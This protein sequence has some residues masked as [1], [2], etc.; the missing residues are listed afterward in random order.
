[1][2]MASLLLNK[3]FCCEIIFVNK[4]INTNDFLS[5]NFN[6]IML[7]IDVMLFFSM[8]VKIV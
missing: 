3:K 6:L 4:V 5:L 1:M 7:T 2:F 8:C